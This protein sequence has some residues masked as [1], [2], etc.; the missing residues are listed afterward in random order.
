MTRTLRRLA[1]YAAGGALVAGGA[2]ALG[3]TQAQAIDCGSSSPSFSGITDSAFDG[4]SGLAPEL[5]SFDTMLD[6]ACRMSFRAGLLAPLLGGDA[7]FF[8]VNTDGN[9]ATGD[10]LADGADAVIATVG[11]NFSNPPPLLARWNGSAID[12]ATGVFLPKLDERGGADASLGQLGISAP[13]QISLRSATVYSAGGNSYRDSA[14][15]ANE[16]P[17]PMF[18]AFSPPAPPPAPP[19][20]PPAPV[21]P[22]AAPVTAARPATSGACTSAQARVRTL[23]RQINQAK[24]QRAKARTVAAR[25]AANKRIVRLTRARTLAIRAARGACPTQ[26]TESPRSSAD[27]VAR[28]QAAFEQLRR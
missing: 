9:P 17:L 21:A 7:L 24:R 20:P 26:Q 10:P 28:L 13:A 11:D 18:V 19:A 1:V 8:I 25:R 6:T 2:L 22:P 15:N 5:T 27:Q 4:Q 16:P 14:P 3:A 23:T 12:F